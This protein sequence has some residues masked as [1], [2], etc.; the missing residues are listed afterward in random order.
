MNFIFPVRALGNQ[1]L[2]LFF[3]WVGV[4]KFIPSSAQV[5]QVPSARILNRRAWQTLPG[6]CFCILIKGQS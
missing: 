2:M 4:R 3:V 1:H 5:A 6:S